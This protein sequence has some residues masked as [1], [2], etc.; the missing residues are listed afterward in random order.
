MT[1]TQ[2]LLRGL[3]LKGCTVTADA[4]HGHPAMAEAALGEKARY[5]QALKANNGP[6]HSDAQR[7]FAPGR[8]DE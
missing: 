8:Q 7:A 4:L 1:A 6:L 2:D 3:L 5:A